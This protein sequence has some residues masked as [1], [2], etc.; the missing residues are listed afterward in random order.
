MG[1]LFRRLLMGKDIRSKAGNN[2]KPR[3]DQPHTPRSGVSA[4]LGT[5]AGHYGAHSIGEPRETP[6]G[7]SENAWRCYCVGMI[8]ADAV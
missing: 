6:F 3:R 7:T 1:C 4:F 8:E 2:T 5:I